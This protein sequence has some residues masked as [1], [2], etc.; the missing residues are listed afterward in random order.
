MMQSEKVAQDLADAFDTLAGQGSPVPTLSAALRKL[1]RRGAQGASPRR[2]LRQGARRGARR[3]RRG[4]RPPSSRRSGRPEFDPRELEQAEER[5]FALRAAARKYAVP[6][7]RL[8]EL[9]ER[10]AADVQ[11]IDAGEEELGAL[12]RAVARPTPPMSRRRERS[13]PAGGAPRRRS[14]ARCRRAA[15]AAARARPLHHRDRTDEESRDPAGFDR[16]S[17]GRRPIP[18]RGRAADEGRVG[19]RARALHAG[20]EGG[21]GRQGLGPDPVF[22]EIDTGVGGAVADAIGQRL[23]RAGAACRSWP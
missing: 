3:A 15:A 8:A 2:S 18:A 7:D 23:A 11:A 6:A 13:P 16:S 22:D 1:E 4:P 17:S 19:R 14:T 12:E 21:A 20:P 10:Y 5:L 9:C